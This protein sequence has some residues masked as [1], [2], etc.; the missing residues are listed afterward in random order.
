VNEVVAQIYEWARVIWRRRWLAL[1]TAWGVALAIWA[2]VLV[3]PDRYEASARVFV[4]ARTALG[5]CSGHS[6]RAGL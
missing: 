2:V 5:L 4:D 6:H 1:A 3:L